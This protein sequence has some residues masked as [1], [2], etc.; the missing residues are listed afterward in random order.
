MY[1]LNRIDQAG[2]VTPILLSVDL[3][4]ICDCAGAIKTSIKQHKY[5]IYNPD[6]ITTNCLDGLTS[7]ERELVKDCLGG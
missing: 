3:Q 2:V 1:I 4:S 5:Q 7:A 6:K